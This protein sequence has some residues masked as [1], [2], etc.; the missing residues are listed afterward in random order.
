MRLFFGSFFYIGY[1]P[2]APG[3]WASLFSLIPIYFISIH[4]GFWGLL[5]LVV[6]SCLIT[7]MT[8][9]QFEQIHKKDAPQMVTD[10]VAGQTTVFLFISFSGT[11]SDA[12]LLLAGFLL[13]RL[14][15]IL[16]PLGIYRIQR[17]EGAH[18]V[19][20]DDLIA[21]L[22]A[23]LCLKFLILLSL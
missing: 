9:S 4:T 12:G 3:T 15:D 21:G 20:F 11:S 2:K 17:L 16:K 6:T 23:F 22:Y 5:V 13:F 10:E 18:G 8:T 14:F 19:L 1:L 7:Y